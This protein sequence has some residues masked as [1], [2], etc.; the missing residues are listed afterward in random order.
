MR[1]P[2]CRLKYEEAIATKGYR[3]A[4]GMGRRGFWVMKREE[5][6]KKR[7]KPGSEGD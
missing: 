1:P 7:I 3:E 6:L 2:K 5:Q 4:G